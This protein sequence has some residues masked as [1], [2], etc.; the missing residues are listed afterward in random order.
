M[1]TLDVSYSMEDTD[2]K[3]NR[4]TAAREAAREFVLKRVSDR[5]GIVVFAT[6]AMLQAP[7]TLDYDALL[8]FLA[9]VRTGMVPARSTAIGNAIALSASHLEKSEAKSKV[10]ILLTD[11]LSND[12]NIPPVEA[13][14][15]AA[16]LGIK[17]YA[18]ATIGSAEEFDPGELM[19]IANITGGKYY[20]AYDT[21]QLNRI[22]AEINALEKTEFKTDDAFSYKDRYSPFLITALTLLLLGFILSK[23]IFVRLP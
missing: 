6:E 4:M 11:G 5:I 19:Q 18:I 13:A 17:I 3:P 9:E 23:T 12:G 10:I 15:A 2:F 7:L 14:A 16:A 8:D 21:N 20:R 1:L 22:Y